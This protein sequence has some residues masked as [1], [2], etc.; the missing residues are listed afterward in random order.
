[1]LGLLA[2]AELL[3]M[4]LWFTGSAVG[5]TLAARWSLSPSE[6]G[7]L[8]TTV[9]LGFVCGTAISA[10]LNLADV[11]PS[12]RLF[13]LAALAGAAVN[14]PLAASSSFGV[15]LLTARRRVPRRGLSLR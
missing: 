4:A 1:M 8:T 2:V 3:G 15:A 9:Q 10:L 7:W 13:A 5:P 14:V 6:V 12:G 11:V